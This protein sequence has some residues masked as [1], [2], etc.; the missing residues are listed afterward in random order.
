LTLNKER[1]TLHL[2]G[3]GPLVKISEQIAYENDWN[4]ILRTGKRFVKSLT[5]LDSRT[6]LL[7]G[8]NL[9]NLIME[10]D[11]PKS[12]DIGLSISAPWIF[13]RNHID[14]FN[15]QLFNIHNQPL[16]IFKGAG[17]S[18]WR[19]LMNHFHGGSCI[20]FLTEG[21]DDGEIVEKVEFKFP[22]NCTYPEDFDNVALSYSSNLIKRWLS[23][24]VSN[25]SYIIK[26][27]PKYK[28]SDSEYWP[29]IN[30]EIHGWINWDWSISDINLFCNAFS[31]PHHGAQTKV[32]GIKVF[33]KKVS[34]Q[35]NNEKFHPFQNGLIY[36]I[37]NNILHVAHKGGTLFIEEHELEDSKVK[38]RL[39]D[40]FFTESN[41][42]DNAMK[43][44]IQYYPDGTIFKN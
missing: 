42:L 43:T 14:K 24:V 7:V 8:D 12:G 28:S 17:G 11:Q 18:S 40:R 22:S 34:I 13:K 15:G 39:G 3:G 10:A 16:P 9:M 23:N 20:H 38:L 30:S 37:T 21:I 5:D 19:I 36:N 33:I 26:K 41:I 27:L 29:R 1:K 44:R 25:S 35:I 31:F 4:V 6:K 32:R 2:F